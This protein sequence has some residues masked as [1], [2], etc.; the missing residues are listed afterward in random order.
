M[1]VAF[2]FGAYSTRGRET[3]S[4]LSYCFQSDNFHFLVKQPGVQNLDFRTGGGDLIL[5]GRLGDHVPGDCGMQQTVE[6][7]VRFLSA[8]QP[9]LCHFQLGLA[10]HGGGGEDFS[11]EDAEVSALRVPSVSSVESSL[12]VLPNES[13]AIGF[14]FFL[15][16]CQFA[17][18]ITLRE[19]LLRS[20]VEN[21]CQSQ[22]KRST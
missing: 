18:I 12:H 3:A 7:G 9:C 22:A 21:R 14:Y 1:P 17:S 16:F 10:D 11:T 8:V 4:L 5:G 15:Q 6:L 19:L 13:Q 20:V 2:V